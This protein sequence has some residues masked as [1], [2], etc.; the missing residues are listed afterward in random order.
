MDNIRVVEPSW[1]SEL[2]GIF[3][4]RC[5]NTDE[6]AVR[7]VIDQTVV[8]NVGADALVIRC[9]VIKELELGSV[10]VRFLETVRIRRKCGVRAELN[11]VVANRRSR[12]EHLH[13]LHHLFD[14]VDG[15]TTTTVT[16]VGVVDVVKEDARVFV[17]KPRLGVVQVVT[18]TN[19]T[20]IARC[21]RR[22][23]QVA[24]QPDTLVKP[25]G[26]KHVLLGGAENLQAS[27]TA[28]VGQVRTTDADPRFV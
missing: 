6:Q 25:R 23:R 16:H 24:V 2:A 27:T 5:P 8:V 22:L 4:G 1:D 18:E 10:K 11:Q 21:G 26:E 9:E 28:V 15:Q 13:R 17:V 7:R 20:P 12:L 14:R 3:A 19:T